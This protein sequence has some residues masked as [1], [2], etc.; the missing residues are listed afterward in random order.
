[1]IVLIPVSK[2]N[3]LRNKIWNSLI[4]G[5]KE[6]TIGTWHCIFHR[7]LISRKNFLSA[8]KWKSQIHTECE[9]VWVWCTRDSS[10]RTSHQLS[11]AL[12]RPFSS[13][14]GFGPKQF[15]LSLGYSWLLLLSQQQPVQRHHGLERLIVSWVSK[16]RFGW[17]FLSLSLSLS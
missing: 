12:G 13:F 11:S 6:E 1:M 15:S 8:S 14:V 5:S 9:Q 4:F 2:Q 10:L 3:F 7:A 16:F 17:I